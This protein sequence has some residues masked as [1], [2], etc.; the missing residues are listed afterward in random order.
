MVQNEGKSVKSYILPTL[1]QAMELPMIQN[2]FRNRQR[3][4]YVMMRMVK[5][6]VMSILILAMAVFMLFGDKLPI[7]MVT[8]LDPLLRYMFGGLCLLYGGF[9][10][11]RSIK[12]DY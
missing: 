3:N 4:A 5:D 2:E 1:Q 8:T 7:D 10:L 11:Y 9:R 6:L 12:K